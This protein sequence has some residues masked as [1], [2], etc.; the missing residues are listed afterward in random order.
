MK[1]ITKS[2][3]REEFDIYS[4]FSGE[5]LHYGAPVSIKF[6]FGYGS[7]FDM[8]DLELHLSDEEAKEILEFV[9]S[10]LHAKTRMLMRKKI[11]EQTKSYDDT[12]EARDWLGSDI[13]FN[14]ISLCNFL[15]GD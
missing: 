3:E 1:H 7:D 5:Y 2:A 6:Q 14:D 4:D 13:T 9:K 15:L 8:A 12:V 11:D 10:R